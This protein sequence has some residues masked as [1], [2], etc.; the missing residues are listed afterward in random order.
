MKPLI[1]HSFCLVIL[2]FSTRGGYHRRA[3]TVGKNKSCGGAR[4][5]L[6][7]NAATRRSLRSM[8]RPSAPI[9]F[10]CAESDCPRFLRSGGL[11]NCLAGSH[12]FAPS[13]IGSHRGL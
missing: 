4:I 11:A 6:H 9:R 13:F 8:Q 10:S 12:P 3:L 5:F 1:S 2:H 7:C